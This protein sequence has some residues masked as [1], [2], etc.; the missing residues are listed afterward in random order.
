M[1]E[2]GM[3][4]LWVNKGEGWS[5]TTTEEIRDQPAADTGKRRRSIWRPGLTFM[6]ERIATI[7][8]EEAGQDRDRNRKIGPIERMLELF[9]QILSLKIQNMEK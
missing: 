1:K 9:Q 4:N 5:R 8:L 2:E 6:T 7:E 3:N